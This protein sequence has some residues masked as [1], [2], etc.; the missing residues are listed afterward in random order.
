MPYPVSQQ[1]LTMLTASNQPSISVAQVWNKNTFL[2]QLGTCTGG[3]VQMD[4]TAQ[5]QRT[6]SAT[7]NSQGLEYDDLVPT[8]PNSLLHPAS[9]N[10]LRLFRGYRYPSPIVAVGGALNG[11]TITQE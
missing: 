8:G 11:Q 2:A 3:S 6:C 1:F 4:V 10:E 7:I 9:G 5:V